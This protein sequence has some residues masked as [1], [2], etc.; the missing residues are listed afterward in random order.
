MSEKK[1]QTGPIQYKFETNIVAMILITLGLVS[2]GGMV[3]IIPLFYLD[4]TME[5]N[6]HKEILWDRQVMA[7]DL[8]SL[9]SLWAVKSI[10]VK[11]VTFAIHR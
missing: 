10:C 6:Q 2:V 11:V 7:C 9:L 3:E 8:I 1:N 5:H 4:E